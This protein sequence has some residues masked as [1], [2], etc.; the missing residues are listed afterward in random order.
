M[1]L[2]ARNQLSGTITDVKLGTIMAEV[3]V[4]IGGQTLVSVI[5]RGSAERLNLKA[6]DTVTVIIKATEI[7][8]GKN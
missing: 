7:M 2:S 4:D 1:E 5:T 3:T 8:L 6:G